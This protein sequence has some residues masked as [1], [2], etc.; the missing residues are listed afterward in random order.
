MARIILRKD[1]TI[2]L[3]TKLSL[4]R[5]RRGGS[6]IRHSNYPCVLT[7]TT[8]VNRWINGRWCEGLVL[9]TWGMNLARAV[10]GSLNPA[11][12]G[13]KERAAERLR[14]MNPIRLV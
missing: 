4:G 10:L 2:S 13:L 11:P 14:L 3:P 6:V 7:G 1:A 8:L 5:L 9:L 12:L